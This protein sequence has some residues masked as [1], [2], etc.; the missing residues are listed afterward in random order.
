[1]KLLFDQNLSHKLTKLLFTALNGGPIFKFNE[2]VSFQVHCDS[3]E[4]VDYFWDR[5]SEGGDKDAQ[6]CDG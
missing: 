6:Q 5:L 2:A 4:E 1:M 3:Q